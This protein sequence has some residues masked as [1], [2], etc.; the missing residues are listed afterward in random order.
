[1]LF[2][3][4]DKTMV[5]LCDSIDRNSIEAFDNHYAGVISAHPPDLVD[6]VAAE[7]KLP[8]AHACMLTTAPR[9]R[10]IDW[11]SC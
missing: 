7:C 2:N 3:V 5:R 6:S 1:M 9:T 10:A 8:L 4:S 11:F